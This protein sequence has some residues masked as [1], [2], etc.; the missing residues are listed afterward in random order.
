MPQL[1]R[2]FQFLILDDDSVTTPLSMAALGDID[3]AVSIAA[4][5]T[6]IMATKEG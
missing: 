5:F 6:Q 4:A 3:I 2:P 1:A